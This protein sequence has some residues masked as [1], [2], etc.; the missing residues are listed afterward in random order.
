MDLLVVQD[1]VDLGPDGAKAN[2]NFKLVSWQDV[3]DA[4]DPRASST[5]AVCATSS[6]GPRQAP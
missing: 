2:Q 1:G 5:G 3:L 6:V 4:L